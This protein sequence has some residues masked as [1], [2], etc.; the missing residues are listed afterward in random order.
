MKKL[1]SLV[2]VL[3]LI[4]IWQLYNHNHEH[5]HDEYVNEKYHSHNQFALKKKL[6]ENHRHPSRLNGVIRFIENNCK[7]TGW[8]D[9]QGSLYDS[10]IS[11]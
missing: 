10:K 11:C 1:F 5:M 4:I 8:V 6:S 3:L 9:N 2:I 7:V